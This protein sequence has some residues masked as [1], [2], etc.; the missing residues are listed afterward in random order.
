M[1]LR[2]DFT[3]NSL[4]YSIWR[5]CIPIRQKIC[6]GATAVKTMSDFNIRSILFCSEQ[7][8]FFFSKEN[9]FTLRV[10]D[11]ESRKT[12]V[13]YG[14]INFAVFILITLYLRYAP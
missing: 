10:I 3:E 7:L 14:E 12:N 8:A 4:L 5:W 2:N 13:I 6:F 11:E 9:R 1:V